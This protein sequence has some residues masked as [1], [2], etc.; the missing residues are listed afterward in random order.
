[1]PE[2]PSTTLSGTVQEVVQFP[3]KPEKAQIVIEGPEHLPTEIRI[4]NRLTDE[5]GQQVHLKPGAKVEVT[6]KAQPEAILFKS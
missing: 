3:S 6:I 2:K 5:S 4:E 1:M